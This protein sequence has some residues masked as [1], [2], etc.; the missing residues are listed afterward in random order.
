MTTYVIEWVT[1]ASA[2]CD[3]II[4]LREVVT[5]HLAL[6]AALLGMRDY[7]VK[8][9]LEILLLGLEENQRIGTFRITVNA[10]DYDDIT[11]VWPMGP[12]TKAGIRL[13]F[14]TA[15]TDADMRQCTSTCA[16]LC[17]WQGS[18][19]GLLRLVELQQG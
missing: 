10:Q 19:N 2:P 16:F 5:K 15:H 14:T 1:P 9:S 13:I 6:G 4:A 3:K 8:R 11:D 17:L 18:L 12:G 7:F